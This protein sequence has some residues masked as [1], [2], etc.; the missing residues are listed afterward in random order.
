MHRIGRGL[1]KDIC[2]LGISGYAVD[3]I[4]QK[5]TMKLED[6]MDRLAKEMAERR[7]G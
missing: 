1:R 2:P 6:L 4:V 5:E 7:D 3:Y